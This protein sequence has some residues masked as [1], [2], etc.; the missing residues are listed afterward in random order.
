MRIL[1]LND[2]YDPRIG[3][4]IRQM[5]QESERLRELGHEAA[6]LSVTQDTGLLA[7]ATFGE[8]EVLGSRVFLAHSDYNPRWRGWV[9]LD[10]PRTRAALAAVLDEYRPDVIHTHLI[11]THLS[12]AALAAARR[13]GAGVVF[14]SHDVMTFCYQKL[15][16]FH[17]GPAAGGE[18]RDYP[19]HWSKCIPCQRLRFRP[20]R[21]AAIR[22]ILA[23]DVDRFT[24][25]SD[26]L[27]RAISANGIRVDRTVW[28]AIRPQRR[29]PTEAEVAAFRV[30]RGLE[31]AQTIAI[32]GRLHEQKGVGQLLQMVAKLAG[33]FPRLRLMVMGKRDVYD[34][35]FA[36]L[37]AELGVAERVVPTGWLDGDELQQAYA[38]VDVFVT[39]SIC[40]DTFGLVNLEA[41]E[42]SKPVVATVFGGSPEVV[43]DGQTGFIVNPFDVDGFA[44]RIAE[45][46]RDPERARAMGAAGHRRMVDF[47]T[48]ERLTDEFIEEYDLAAAAARARSGTAR[49]RA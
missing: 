27:G 2:L 47:F 38:A 9:G 23:R 1:H 13:R 24:V 17:G 44:G 4:S 36:P 25:V 26:E 21:N 22:R 33:E 43:L 29:L 40:F 32:G 41:M 31:G 8:Q 5:Y 39:P 28:N 18:L 12:Y 35:E 15:T 19:A 3:S 20:G 14:T 11:H 6:V 16:C 46:L 10:N 48:I 30:A 34:R 7:G 42:H 45:L 49:S 37:A